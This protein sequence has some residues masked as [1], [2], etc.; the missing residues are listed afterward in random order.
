MSHAYVSN[1]MHCTFS[2]KDRYPL[3]NSELESR[4][5]PYF[6]G[7]ARDN[8]MKALAIGGT[9]DHIH[10]LLSLPGMMS[11][12]KAIQLL[13]G[14]SSKWIHD[15]FAE[16]NKFGWQE[17]YGAFSVSASQVD[18]TIAYI[19]NQKEH[20]RRRTFREEFLELLKKHGIE[21]DARYIL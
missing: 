13:K 2:T 11:F 3:I 10:A 15:T 4:L 21:Y 17:G 9:P 6:G 5:W 18:K 20:H 1:L 7:I 16:Q 19:N 12:A 14:G 8:R